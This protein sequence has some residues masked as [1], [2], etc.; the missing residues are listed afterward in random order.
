MAAEGKTP[1]LET[2]LKIDRI[3]NG[4]T[5]INNNGAFSTD[6]IGGSWGYPQASYEQRARIW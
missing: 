4:K 5:D 6:Y 2:F 3:P 1:A